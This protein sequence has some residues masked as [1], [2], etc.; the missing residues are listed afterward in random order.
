[1]KQ[2]KVSSGYKMTDDY[3]LF[4]VNS[5]QIKTALPDFITLKYIETKQTFN[6]LV[7]TGVTLFISLLALLVYL[8]RSKKKS[9]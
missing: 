5:D 3:L 1:M 8:I 6:I 2:T 9:K 4:E 7:S